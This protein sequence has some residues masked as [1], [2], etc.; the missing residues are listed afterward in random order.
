MEYAA[1]ACG[2]VGA[3]STAVGLLP[4]IVKSLC[5]DA[6]QMKNVS[7]GMLLLSCVSSYATLVYAVH[8]QLP[9]IIMS[10]GGCAAMA[11][12]LTLMK[13][14]DMCKKKCSGSGHNEEAC[15]VEIVVER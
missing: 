11:T 13:T 8:Y 4:Q 2:W 3:T 12:C 7:M 5:C 14:L 15:E 10:N 9:P 6:C 1:I